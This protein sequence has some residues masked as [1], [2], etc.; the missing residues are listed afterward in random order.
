M[1]RPIGKGLE[2]QEICQI[3]QGGHGGNSRHA[4]QGW[5]M[6]LA[7]SRR[8]DR[9]KKRLW[10]SVYSSHVVDIWISVWSAF[11]SRHTATVERITTLVL[12][13]SNGRGFRSTDCIY[14]EPQLVDDIPVKSTST[15]RGYKKLWPRVRDI[16]AVGRVASGGC[17]HLSVVFIQWLSF[18]DM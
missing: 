15:M 17:V 13:D 1:Q 12:D 4:T 2:N 14:P 6:E 3:V 8:F 10:A 11:S 7:A 18:L 9:K 5:Q 16:P